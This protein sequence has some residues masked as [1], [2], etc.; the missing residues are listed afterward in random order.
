MSKLT[1]R[2][3][4]AFVFHFA[5]SHSSLARS[6]TLMPL[7]KQSS[8]R[9]YRSHSPSDRPRGVQISASGLEARWSVLSG[10][11]ETWIGGAKGSAASVGGATESE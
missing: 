10:W 7:T 8:L 3:P 4:F 1:Q 2:S 5:S 9:E 11:T 6:G